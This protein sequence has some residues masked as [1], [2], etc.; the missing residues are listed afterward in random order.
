M[1]VPC[2]T[3]V[4][5][6]FLARSRQRSRGTL[7]GGGAGGGGKSWSG[8][9]GGVLGPESSV[10]P[11]GVGGWDSLAPMVLPAFDC[12][13]FARCNQSTSER[14][15]ES[16]S[17]TTSV[18]LT[19]TK[20]PA[21]TRPLLRMT[22]S[23]VGGYGGRRLTTTAEADPGDVPFGDRASIEPT[24]V[25]DAAAQLADPS[26]AVSEHRAASVGMVRRI[27]RALI[28]VTAVFDHQT[29]VVVARKIDRLSDVVGISSCN[30]ERAGLTRPCIDLPQCQGRS[31]F[32]ADVVWVLQV[33]GD[34]LCRGS[35]E[36]P[37]TSLRPSSG[38]IHS[39]AWP[40]ATERRRVPRT[41]PEHQRYGGKLRVNT[42]T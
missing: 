4:L 39:W 19:P 17:K 1:N 8:R 12:G 6:I 11:G 13:G 14:A 16:S 26:A 9:D 23:V 41:N 36:G 5:G 7:G 25:A 33:F 40:V 38:F 35:R 32:V 34:E 31:R 21:L 30:R 20:C 18:K 37:S 28:V 42:A 22:S 27:G 2:Q 10:P 24:A 3:G 15:N 29:Q